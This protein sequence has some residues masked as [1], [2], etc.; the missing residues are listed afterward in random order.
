[1]DVTRFD[2]YDP[3]RVSALSGEGIQ[4]L[5]TAVKK[6]VYGSDID[7][8]PRYFANER[9]KSAMISARAALFRAME[10]LESGLSSDFASIDLEDAYREL[11]TI[12]G[13]TAGDDVIDR[14]FADFCL[15]K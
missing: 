12:T 10:T 3:V 13:E 14:I 6:L 11:G 7:E 4:E 2:G 9:H 5:K 8:T 15:G 1:M